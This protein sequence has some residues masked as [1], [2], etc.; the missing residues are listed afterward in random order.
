MGLLSRRHR[1]S[2]TRCVRDV[3]RSRRASI[4]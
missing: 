3:R 2:H 4:T 1:T